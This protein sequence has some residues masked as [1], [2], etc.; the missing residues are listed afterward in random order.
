M[1]PIRINV[2]NPGGAS[3]ESAV[4]EFSGQGLWRLSSA[5]VGGSSPL[6][7]GNDNIW[8]SWTLGKLEWDNGCTGIKQ[9][10]RCVVTTITCVCGLSLGTE[11]S[12][13]ETQSLMYSLMPPIRSFLR[14]ITA[15]NMEIIGGERIQWLTSSLMVLP[16]GVL[17]VSRSFFALA[18]EAADHT[19]QFFKTCRTCSTTPPRDSCP[20]QWASCPWRSASHLHRL[21]PQS[22]LIPTSSLFSQPEGQKLIL[23]LVELWCPLVL[24]LPFQLHSYQLYSWWTNL[25]IKFSLFK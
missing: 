6:Y 8:F 4:C 7:S 17:S 1:D 12:V 18:G 2:W 15:L 3:Q 11:W 25:Y 10:L 22:L 14:E 20:S 24:F 19:W 9:M 21:P 23:P 16:M 13:W 5:S